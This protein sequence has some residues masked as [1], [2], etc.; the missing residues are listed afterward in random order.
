MNADTFIFTSGNDVIEDFSIAQKDHLELD[1]ALWSNT[2]LTDAQVISQF[3]DVTAKGVLF[4]FGD[5]NTLL[6]EHV[7]S[8]DGLDLNINIF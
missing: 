3:A 7:A 1:D 4:D 5:G 2:T 6:L 8:L